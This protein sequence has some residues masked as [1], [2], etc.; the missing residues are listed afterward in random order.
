MKIN[1]KITTNNHKIF[2]NISYDEMYISTHTIQKTLIHIKRNK[3]FA[4][5]AQ[6]DLDCVCVCD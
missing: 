5:R 6:M 3:K 2:S 4:W 1:E